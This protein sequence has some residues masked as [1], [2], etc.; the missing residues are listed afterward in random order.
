MKV[1]VTTQLKGN[2]TWRKG[3][4][5]DTDTDGPLPSDLQGEV[6]AGA[7]TVRVLEEQPAMRTQELVPEKSMGA[8]SE[9]QETETPAFEPGKKEEERLE[10]PPVFS[11]LEKPLSEEEKPALLTKE[12]TRSK[13]IGARKAELAFILHARLPDKFPE[14]GEPGAATNSDKAS[15][16]KL[17]VENLL[18]R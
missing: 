3:H 4:V 6:N 13:L 9:T 18:P 5:W 16:V 1:E 11:H 2:Q 10:K 12:W 17:A 8:E 15:L 14:L 7:N